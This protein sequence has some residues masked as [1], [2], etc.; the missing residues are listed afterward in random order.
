MKDFLDR[1]RGHIVIFDGAM[2]TM[3][4]AEGLSLGEC[5]E[6]WNIEHPE[7]V[8]RIHLAYFKAGAEVVQTNTFGANRAKL[9]SYGLETKT[10]DLNCRGAQLAKEVAPSNC[11]VAG[12]ISPTGRFLEPLGDLS[13]FQLV[14]IY[15]EQ[16]EGLAEG[17]ADL[18]CIETMLDPEEAAAAIQA[19]RS[20]CKLPVVATMTFNLDRVG[21][22]TI[23]GTSPEAAIRRLEEAGAD[24]LGS[25]CGNGV[26]EMVLLMK[27]MRGLT[28]WPLLAQ[29]NAGLPQLREGKATYSQSPEDFAAE[30]PELLKAGVNGIG[31]CCGTTPEHI[32]LMAGRIRAEP[33]PPFSASDSRSPLKRG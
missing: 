12:S 1:L 9:A 14:K 29:P 21:F 26:K 22:R 28:S 30:I 3:L 10:H 8:Q 7:I 32:H 6:L 24:V 33:L 11:L 18:L 19:A 13:F 2:G 23:M 4:Q 31:G 5:A 15:E 16:I 25:N 27:E 20:V 17:G